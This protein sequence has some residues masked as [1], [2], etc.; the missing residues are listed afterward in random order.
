MKLYNLKSKAVD[1]P[2][3]SFAFMPKLDGKIVSFQNK[4]PACLQTDGFLLIL[5]M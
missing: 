4:K 2:I 5:T 3:S 1:K